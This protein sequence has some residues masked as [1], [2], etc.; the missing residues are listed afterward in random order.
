[1]R[2]MRFLRPLLAS[3]LLLAAA[4]AAAEPVAAPP[5]VDPSPAMAVEAV[6]TPAAAR[7]TVVAAPGA[8]AGVARSLAEGLVDERAELEAL[9]GGLDAGPMEIR[10][11]YGREEFEA[12]QPRGGRAPGW[13]AGVAWPSLGLVVI[14]ARASG[15]GGDVRA[16][17]R[18]ELAH[19]ALGRLIRG[20]VPRW[21][22]EG[23]AQLYAGEWT[24]SRSATLARAVSSDALIP[25]ADLETGWPGTPTDVD[26]AYAQ[27]V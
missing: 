9:L 18:H 11:A 4:P 26:L 20:H 8:A 13:A 10:F 21:F 2:Q 24:L 15:R 17:L 25:V 5:R 6:E 7:M 22:T 19:V 16:V 27:S 1:G 23:F 14:D 12:L 3:L